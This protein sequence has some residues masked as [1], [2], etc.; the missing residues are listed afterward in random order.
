MAVLEGLVLDS[1]LDLNGSGL[2]LESLSIPPPP[3]R[4]EWADGADVDGAALIRDPLFSNREITVKVRVGPLATM[5]LALASLAAISKKLEE[6]EQWPDGLPLTWTPATSTSTITFYVLSGAVD[7]LPVELTGEDAGW[8]VRSPVVTLK[9]TCKPFGYGTEVV[10]SGVSGS[11][12]F[13]TVTVPSVPGDVPAEGRLVVTDTSAQSRRYVEW[14]LEQRYYN[15]ATSLAV[16]SDAMVTTGFGGT[17]TTRTGAVDADA[18]GNNVIRVAALQPTVTAV[19]GLGNLAHVG[20][21][22]VKCRVWASAAGAKVR[23]SWKDGDGPL[24]SNAYATPPAVGVFSETD[25]GI[26]TIRPTPLGTQQWT[27]QIEALTTVSGV[28]IDI[29]Q[30][31]LVPVGEGYGRARGQ[32]IQQVG[33]LV[34]AD[35][36]AGSGALN[37]RSAPVGGSWASTGSTTDF[38]VGS[39]KLSRATTSDASPRIAVLGSSMT[40]GVQVAGDLDGSTYSGPGPR[41]G[42]I[43][44]YVDASNYLLVYADSNTIDPF[45][46]LTLQKVVAGV[47]TVLASGT[48]FVPPATVTLIVGADGTWT[49]LSST[50]GTSQSG[51]DPVLATGGALAGGK[52]GVY[53][54]NSTAS[55]RTRIVDNF[56]ASSIP[57]SPPALYASRAVEFRSDGTAIRQDPTGAYYGP[58]PAYRGS[59]FVIPPAGDKNRTSRILVKAD[60]N[61]L[62]TAADEP[63]GDGITVQV[64]YTP[65]YATVGA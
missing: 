65:R 27:G 60:R 31:T 40:G 35:D 16:D 57:P 48:Q 55:A 15:S 59:R 24:R 51:N 13:V 11:G 32:V 18:T 53:D 38:A 17:Q 26:V 47:S 1:T 64:R 45:Q 52:V 62:E 50:Y 29:D 44:R 33:A 63:L 14:G 43:A 39:G 19:C 22:R 23:L 20:T 3:K 49:L 54:Y 12:P 56:A 10:L 21:F 28:S 9:L 36:F 46:I 30:I 42:L 58:V 37:A 4:P 61:D 5:D 34:A 25:L 8:F 7:G 41:V 2:T 6:T